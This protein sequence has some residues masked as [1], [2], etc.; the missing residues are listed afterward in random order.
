[1]AQLKPITTR[2]SRQKIL[3]TGG[4][5]NE[6]PT[7]S[8]NDNES[9]NEYGWDTD[10]YPGIHSRKGRTPYGATG[11]AQT[12]LLTNYLLTHMVRSVGTKLQYNSSGTTWTDISGTFTD[13][14]WDA[15][16]FNAKLLL[17]NGTDNVK[18]WNGSALSDLN[19]TNAPKGKYIAN[20]TIRV[21][22]AKGT[23]I[24]FSKYLD[25]TNWT[26]TDSAGFFEYYTANGGDITGLRAFNDSV[27][28]FKKD[29]M[30]EIIGTGNTSQKHRLVVISNTIGCVSFKTIQEVSAPQG[31]FLFFLGQ[32]D[33]Y[34]FSGG[35]P[36]SIGN[37]IRGYL[38]AINPAQIGRC[39]GATDGIRYF[40]GLVTGANTQP[41]TF[42]MFDPRYGIWRVNKI[43]DNLR[44]SVLFNNVWYTGDATGQTYR[45]QQ[46]Q[47]DNGTPISWMVTTKD[48]DE[49]VR[50][51][52]KE[53]YALHLQFAAAPGSSL[54]IQVSIDQGQNYIT[55]GDPITPITIVQNANEIIPLDTVP[56]S[57]WIRFRFMGSGDFTLHEAQRMFLVHPVQ[58]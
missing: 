56:I 38:S 55:I 26:D 17:T 13:T 45:M 18:S 27:F 34:M 31:N 15:T 49:G 10:S 33:V 1:M 22:I 32:N 51:A 24:Y 36:S 5:N 2:G 53:Y 14:D 9:I 50:E 6:A 4:L 3:F 7:I 41:D 25:E 21:F 20:N 29:S 35:R 16:N 43:N 37:N 42:L 11:G 52:E 58:I 48:F 57:N 46:G 23:T 39:F 40:L 44:Y 47:S 19:A 28:A 54:T 30:A 8:V 12:N